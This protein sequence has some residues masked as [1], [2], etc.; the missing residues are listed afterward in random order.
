MIVAL[1]AAL[2]SAQANQEQTLDGSPV[3]WMAERAPF[4]MDIT[5]DRKVWINTNP[6]GARDDYAILANDLY[7][8]VTLR[9]V[10]PRV[11]VR[12]Y[13]IKNNRVGYRESKQLVSIDCLQDTVWV[14]RRILY[15]ASGYVIR[16]LIPQCGGTVD[17]HVWREDLWARF[18]T[19]AP[20]RLRQCV[21]RYS[22]VKRA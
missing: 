19:A 1:A 20:R 14:Q 12:G 8:A 5:L 11:W 13:H 17:H 10:G 6:V 3:E 21:E 7:E 9:S 15:D 22:G 16:C 18:Y 2:W 4:G